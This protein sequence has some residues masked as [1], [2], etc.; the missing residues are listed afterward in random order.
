MLSICENFFDLQGTLSLPKFANTG[1]YLFYT[2]LMSFGKRLLEARKNRNLSQDYLAEKLGT[3][4]PAIG[5]YERDE[6]K[7]SIDAAAKMA[8][9]LDVS[10]DWLVGHTDLEL[11]K[12]LI[13]RIQEVSKMQEKEKEHVFTMLDTFIATSKMQGFLAK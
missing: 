3:K 9:L 8:N 5:R 6:M 12:G 1:M 10:L 7:P 11:N 4:G 13:K 2:I